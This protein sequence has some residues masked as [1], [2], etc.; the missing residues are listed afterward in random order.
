MDSAARPLHAG[1]TYQHTTNSFG[2]L[3]ARMSAEL[4]KLQIRYE[5]T[6][7]ERIGRYHVDV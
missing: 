3:P 2:T 4:R 6:S 5:A 1:M 7:V